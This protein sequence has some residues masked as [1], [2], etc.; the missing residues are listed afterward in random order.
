M[1]LEAYYPS[2]DLYFSQ[3]F[4]IDAAEVERYGAIDISVASDIPLFIDPFLLFYSN[5][6]EYQALHEGILKYLQFLRDKALKGG[7]SA[8]TVKHL[9]YFKEVK[10]NWLGFTVL[11]NEG[12]GLG[13]K[14]AT[15]MRGSLG[16][17]FINSG[18]EGITQGSHLEK[19]ALISGD[20][21]RDGISDFTACLI[22]DYLAE[23]TQAF[24]LEYLSEDQRELVS[25][26][27]AV[28][29]YEKELWESKS[30]TLPIVRDDFVLLT[31]ADMLTRDDTWINSEDMARRFRQIAIGLPN[32]EL[33]AAVNSY[34]DGKLGEG[35]PSRSDFR[36]AVHDTIR[37]YPDLIDYYI[38]QRE[39]SGK[40]AIEKSATKV[41]DTE[42]V[43]IDR[44]KDV[45]DDIRSKT[46]FYEENFDS[47]EEAL[48]RAKGFKHYVENQDGYR[49]INRNGQPFSDEKEVQLFFGLIWFGSRFDV[50]REPNNGRGPVDYKI[51][52]GSADKS[53]IEFKLGS[54]TQL[55][56]NLQK[57]VEIYE[58]ANQTHKSVKVIVFYTA[59]QQ[60][61]VNG[62]LAELKLADAE[63]IV[64]I[65]ARSDNKPSASK[66]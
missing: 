19:V 43:F 41:R 17:V 37:E 18:T 21:G 10:Q 39:D 24:A 53:L 48:A 7:M 47:Y 32:D 36:K 23:H 27:R 9:F 40:E 56:R 4:G 50:N 59:G 20:V 54:N 58:K 8:G 62:I 33:R 2:M 63:N 51:S 14:F 1:I 5:K 6:P 61:G 11:G 60:A 22:K 66:A 57:Q 65:D 26:P 44:L 30:Y 38:K 28:F 15:G 13:E 55:K 31:P 46:S 42:D 45:F 25:V 29:N 12:L 34:F 16:T 49:L 3:Y 52:I 35:K 64:L